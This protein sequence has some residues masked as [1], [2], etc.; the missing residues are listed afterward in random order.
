MASPTVFKA[1]LWVLALA[2]SV[3]G[4]ECRD[5]MVP[6]SI[7]ARQGVYNVPPLQHN[8]DATTFNQKLTSIRGNFTDAILTGYDDVTGNY[9]ISAQFCQP[10]QPSHSNGVV[11]FLTHGIGFD[12]TSVPMCL[13]GNSAPYNL[14]GKAHSESQILGLANR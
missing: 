13:R 12:K 8:L 4:K 7:S 3:V 6:V 5:F 11:Q 2:A 14:T 10:D 1:M 9:Y